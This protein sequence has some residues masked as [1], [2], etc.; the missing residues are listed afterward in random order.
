MN[1][2]WTKIAA[3]TLVSVISIAMVALLLWNSPGVAAED[4][5]DPW[6]SSADP[7]AEI[8]RA[9]LSPP[10]KPGLHSNRPDEA[11]ELQSVIRNH[12]ITGSALRPRDSVVDFDVNT[13]GACIYAENNAFDVF[14]T[15]LWLPQG[16]TVEQ[17]RMY[18]NDTS[19]SNSTAWFTV[20][21]LYGDIVD[22]WSVSSSG[23]TG[24]SFNDTD[25]I[26]HTIDYN[27]YSYL[28]NWR[29]TVAG[30][31]MQLCGFRIF[32]EAPPFGVQ[33]LPH[34]QRQ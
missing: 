8:S 25:P 18:Y 5:L 29:P 13:T 11:A 12:R 9:A 3:V 27:T 21:D 15:P 24:N 19:S 14:N 4:V 1:R 31:S 33:F 7:P 2:K 32:Y 16:A 20:Y 6:L 22:E 34:V 17:V 30:D 23:D 28:L 10:D 26:S